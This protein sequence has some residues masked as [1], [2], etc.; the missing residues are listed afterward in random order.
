MFAGGESKICLNAVMYYRFLTNTVT[1]DA[2]YFRD[3]LQ[4]DALN[5]SYPIMLR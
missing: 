1:K 2:K 5:F 3:P 4:L